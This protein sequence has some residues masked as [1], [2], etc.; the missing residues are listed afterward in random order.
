MSILFS[1]ITEAPDEKL[2]ESIYIKLQMLA[3]D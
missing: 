3:R 2:H 1:I